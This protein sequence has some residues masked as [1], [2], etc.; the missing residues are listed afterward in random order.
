MK[1]LTQTEI[2]AL[3]DCAGF[4]FGQ[5][6]W[7]RKTMAKLAAKGLTEQLASGAYVLTAE[8]TIARKRYIESKPL[9]RES[10]A[11]TEPQPK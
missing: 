3:N 9:L 2:I 6:W 5:Y 4:P 8:G 10:P 7:K 1:T 11:T